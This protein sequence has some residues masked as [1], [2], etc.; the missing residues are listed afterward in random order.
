[1][2]D[3]IRERR[4][5]YTRKLT[6]VEKY[7]PRWKE[8]VSWTS[9]YISIASSALYVRK[10]FNKKSKHDALELVDPIKEEFRTTLKTIEWMDEKTRIAAIEKALKMTNFIG[11]PDEL[12]DDQKLIEFYENLEINKKEFFKSF[13][14]LNLFSTKKEL[15][16]FR[17]PVNKT[18]WEDHAEVALVNAFYS[19]MENSIRKHKPDRK[20]CP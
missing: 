2:S 18:D 11:Y 9:N 14:K 8:C 17:E 13:L 4:L 3:D 5:Q 19:P 15:L 20:L 1:M 10:Y 7:K 6:G 12:N 16:K